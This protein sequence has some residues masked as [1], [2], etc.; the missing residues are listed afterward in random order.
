M[1]GKRLDMLK[2]QFKFEQAQRKKAL[3]NELASES[4]FEKF[5]L[6]IFL[7]PFL[8]RVKLTFSTPEGREIV[9]QILKSSVEPNISRDPVTWKRYEAFSKEFENKEGYPGL[10]KRRKRKILDDW[11]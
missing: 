2:T 8:H 11:T 3:D 9:I 1:A 4:T 10:F 6:T 5:T 7:L